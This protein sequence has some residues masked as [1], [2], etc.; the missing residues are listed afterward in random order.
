MFPPAKGTAGTSSFPGPDRRC[1]SGPPLPRRSGGVTRGRQMPRGMP[2]T[3]KR[4]KEPPLGQRPF[5]IPE[6]APGAGPMQAPA[7]PP[8]VWGPFGQDL[9][10]GRAPAGRKG[11]IHEFRGKVAV[12]GLPSTSH[13]RTADHG[14]GPAASR[15]PSRRP[16]WSAARRAREPPAISSM[17]RPTGARG[18]DGTGDP[19]GQDRVGGRCRTQQNAQ[20]NRRSLDA[21][22]H[23]MQAP[24]AIWSLQALTWIA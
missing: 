8:I 7:G 24:C 19:G 14:A 20:R 16:R 23:L 10:Y 12:S 15:R 6:Q 2:G 11:F 4:P 5:R 22:P 3:T 18:F 9:H 17:V 1:R 21:P 13:P